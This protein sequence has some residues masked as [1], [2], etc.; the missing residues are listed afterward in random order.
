MMCVLRCGIAV[1]FVLTASAQTDF[2]K[3]TWGMTRAQVEASES[4][5]PSVVRESNGE[6]IVEYHAIPFASLPARVIYI[7]ADNQLARAKFI[8][9]REHHD[10]NE[11][12]ADYRTIEPVLT[13]MLG[14]PGSARAIWNDDSTQDEPKSYLDQDR[15]TPASILPSD[16]LVGLAV[17]LGHLRLYTEWSSTRTTIL[18]ALTGENHNIIHQVEYRGVAFAALENTVRRATAPVN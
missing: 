6:T 2:R 16:P 1:V 7:F 18:H 11:F 17:S 10:Q 4:N 9:S 5:P 13:K 14:K 12:I 3:S 8:F 15:A